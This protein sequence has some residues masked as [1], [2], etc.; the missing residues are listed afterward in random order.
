MRHCCNCCSSCSCI[1][2]AA[3]AQRSIQASLSLV[4]SAPAA[5][6]AGGG[7]A[8]HTGQAASPMNG[9]KHAAWNLHL[10]PSRRRAESPARLP[11]AYPHIPHTSPPPPANPRRGGAWTAPPAAATAAPCSN[12]AGCGCAPVIQGPSCG[13]AGS[14][15]CDGSEL[16]CCSCCFVAMSP[17]TMPASR[18]PSATATVLATRSGGAELMR[19][20]PRPA[21]RCLY[22]FADK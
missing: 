12:W 20:P 6:C 18:L 8:L 14:R 13:G 17:S 3:T 16:S 15:V 11:R 10:Q 22:I 7:L 2:G 9:A 1:Q 19:Y 21:L 4:L 5:G